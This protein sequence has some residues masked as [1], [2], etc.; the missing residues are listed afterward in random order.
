MNLP[1]AGVTN[2]TPGAVL[3]AATIRTYFNLVQVGNSPCPQCSAPLD[4]S[5]RVCTEHDP[6]DGIC[7]ACDHRYGAKISHRRPNRISDVGG[8]FANWL[9]T[10]FEFVAF[11]VAHEVNP[12]APT[13]EDQRIWMDYD[14]EILS[15]DPFEARF[16]F[17]VDDDS[18]TLTVET[19]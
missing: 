16:T 13:P 15:V 1:P 7:E 11:L 12:V 4:T 2:R 19:A 14:E 5:V 9:L 3:D 6:A 10:N 18:L 17:T 8:Y